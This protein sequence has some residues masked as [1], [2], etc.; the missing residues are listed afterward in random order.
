MKK[1]TSILIVLASVLMNNFSIAET[2]QIG[3]PAPEFALLDQHSTTHS[4]EN[5][6][7]QWVVLYFYPKDDTPGCTKEACAFR[8][9]YRTLSAQNTQVLGVSVDSKDSHAEFAEKYSLPFPLL[10]DPKGLTAKKYQSLMSLGPIKFAKRHTFIIDP[11]GIT[12]Q[13]YR[14]VDPASHSDQIL[15]ALKKL[16]S[17]NLL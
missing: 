11:K 4:L 16:Q 12:R 8:D 3:Q 1:I 2:I 14:K 10:A 6:R 13:I 9:D 7:G 17:E 5:Y 15:D